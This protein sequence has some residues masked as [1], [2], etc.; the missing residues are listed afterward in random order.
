MPPKTSKKSNTFLGK[1]LTSNTDKSTKDPTSP[2]KDAKVKK[3]PNKLRKPN[4][5][6]TGYTLLKEPKKVEDAKKARR[7]EVLE[8]RRSARRMEME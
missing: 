7:E 5:G 4:V 6:K 3:T 8:V 1:L 2:V